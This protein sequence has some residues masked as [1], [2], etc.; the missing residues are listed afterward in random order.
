MINCDPINLTVRIWARKLTVN[1]ANYNPQCDDLIGSDVECRFKGRADEWEIFSSRRCWANSFVFLS[2]PDGTHSD[3][4]QLTLSTNPSSPLC[5]VC[6]TDFAHFFPLDRNEKLS[7]NVLQVWGWRELF[8]NSPIHMSS[9][10]LVCN[11]R[12]FGALSKTK[13]SFTLASC[14]MKSTISQLY[15]HKR[16]LSC[17]F[18]FALFSASDIINIRSCE[19]RWLHE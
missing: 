4:R 7:E 19:Q 12:R 6:F 13:R 2:S 8:L 1:V 3:K 5:A 9:T 17:P 16:R 10:S 15:T 14:G 18:R 11:H